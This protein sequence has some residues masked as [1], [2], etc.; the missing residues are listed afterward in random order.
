MVWEYWSSPPAVMQPKANSAHPSRADLE[1][2]RFDHVEIV[3]VP[4]IGF[5]DPP[6]AE[7]FAACHRVAH[8]AAAKSAGARTRL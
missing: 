6:T 4:Q 7:Q 8:G 3:A 1:I 5:D 2:G